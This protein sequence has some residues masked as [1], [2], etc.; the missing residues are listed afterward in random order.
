MFLTSRKT[1]FKRVLVQRKF[2]GS[3]KSENEWRPTGDQQPKMNKNISKSDNSKIDRKFIE[4]ILFSQDEEKVMLTGKLVKRA[5]KTGDIDPTDE[6]NRV[7]T[8]LSHE[9]KLERE[10]KLTAEES[11]IEDMTEFKSQ[12]GWEN[13]F[14]EKLLGGKSKTHMYGNVKLNHNKK[15]LQN[16]ESKEDLEFKQYKKLKGSNFE[17]TLDQYGDY[18]PEGS[19]L[20]IEEEDGTNKF[21]N[22]TNMNETETLPELPNIDRTDFY[23]NSLKLEPGKYQD[24]PN[25]A[26]DYLYTKDQK[27][28]NISIEDLCKI[29][30]INQQE[31][32]KYFSFSKLSK[33]LED[34]FER[35][36]QRALMLRPSIEPVLRHL[37][38]FKKGKQVK[39]GYIF[40]G[41]SG[42]GKSSNLTSIVYHSY[43]QNMLV[44]HIPNGYFWTRGNQY[45]VP[46]PLL[47]G[48]F[49]CPIPTESFLKQFKSGNETIIK[50]MK[51]SKDYKLPSLTIG[52]DQYQNP[53]TIF[54]LC[55]Y[56]LAHPQ[57]LLITFKFLMDELLANK[58]VPMVFAIDDY[59]FFD[60]FT[61][62]SFGDIDDEEATEL[63]KKIH[64]KQ[65]TL[66]RGLDRI[67]LEND[68]NKTFICAESKKHKIIEPSNLMDRNALTA[69][70]VQRYNFRELNRICAYYMA[71]NYVYGTPEIFL[72][73]LMFLTGGIPS[74]IFKEMMIV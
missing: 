44:F 37:K 11:Y 67:L 55:Q 74:K 40:T 41:M 31:Y 21:I 32:D 25:S 45:V 2:Y 39:R 59:N 15:K 70:H 42:C 6:I 20:V 34:T 3:K 73:D 56:G 38:L 35:V 50:E 7:D 54:E 49:D 60:H 13:S 8:K 71:A 30:I 43:S 19:Q 27:I 4:K 33:D 62:Y 29:F 46:S 9:E 64:A 66:V 63:P 1:I 28:K 61:P 68:S 48:Y 24:E 12:Y 14:D 47:Q 65:Y 18:F 22:L 10:D 23:L 5:K 16:Y 53:T 52:K 26:F 58:T 36:Q 72:E 51:L 17:E 57:Y 69:I